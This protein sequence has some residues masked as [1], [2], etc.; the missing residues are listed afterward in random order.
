M[1]RS[2]KSAVAVVVLTVAWTGA[3]LA[4]GAPSPAR[5]PARPPDDYGQGVRAVLAG[6]YA[7]AVTLLGRAVQSDPKNADAWNY[8][9]FSYRNLKRFDEAMAAYQKALALDPHHR[10]AHEYL[11]ELYLQM[12]QVARAREVLDRLGR[13][14]P[15]GCKEHDDLSKAIAAREAGGGK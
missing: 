3:A 9:G 14:C 4:A 13:L 5:P 2:I 6:D 1:K 15:S 11:G 10:G 12:G 7:R 8:L